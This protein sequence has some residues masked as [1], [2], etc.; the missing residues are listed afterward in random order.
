MR[1][2]P[3]FLGRL[4][5][6]VAATSLFVS[7]SAAGEFDYDFDGT[8]SDVFDPLFGI[9][10]QV[11]VQQNGRLEFHNN[12]ISAP[13]DDGRGVVHRTFQP[14]Y[15]ESWTASVEAT[16]PLSYNQFDGDPPASN[17]EQL[18]EY[19]TVGIAAA[20]F[21]GSIDDDASQ[22]LVPLLEVSRFFPQTAAT[23][24]LSIDSGGGVLQRVETPVGTATIK[25]SF[26]ATTK[27]F[28]VFQDD[29]LLTTVDMMIRRGW[30]G[31]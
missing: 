22:F 23:R 5:F 15:D 24:E 13:T 8:L 11:L 12:N 27:T 3:R 21:A 26:D 17:D 30:T 20:F 25:L 1:L 28:S 18:D 6:A 10:E 19:L 9:P 31:G 4:F 7:P 29:F 14:R 2:L 16:I